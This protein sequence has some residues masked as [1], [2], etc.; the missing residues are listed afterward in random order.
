MYTDMNIARSNNLGRHLLKWR[1]GT[2]LGPSSTSL[3]ASKSRTKLT[4]HQ[5]L[6]SAAMLFY[7]QG[8]L[9]LQPTHTAR[10]KKQGTYTHAALND[11]GFLAAI[12]GLIVIE[13]NKEPDAHWESPHG[14]MGLTTYI[15]MSIQLIVGITQYFTPG[16]YGSVDNAKALYKYHRVWGYLTLLTML[17][18]ICAATQ[19]T[20]NFNVLGVQL[21]AVIVACVLIVV[22]LAPRIRLS[23]LGYSS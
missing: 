14:I 5:L 9:I 1:P 23:K 2:I 10:Q 21:W 3:A 6:N 18:T 16:L 22:G 19:T 20:F 12:G 15:M 7:V 13:L 11:V 4:F 8:I 17:A